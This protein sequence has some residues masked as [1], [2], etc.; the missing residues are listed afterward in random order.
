MFKK[1]TWNKRT[2]FFYLIVTSILWSASGVS[3]DILAKAVTGVIAFIMLLIAIFH[4]G[5]SFENKRNQKKFFIYTSIY[6]VLIIV[7]LLLT[8]VFN[9]DTE[10]PLIFI[11]FTPIASTLMIVMA[12]DVAKTI[13]E[14]N[15][16]ESDFLY[17]F[18]T[19]GIFA[20]LVTFF[21]MLADFF[22]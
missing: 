5:L 17:F 4:Y 3:E 14:K 7:L 22:A 11:I 8:E 18:A 21:I 6:T 15:K 20:S 10:N 12:F 1:T 19:V 2:F 9:V 13:R 16:K